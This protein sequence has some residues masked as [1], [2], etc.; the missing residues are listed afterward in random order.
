MC[1]EVQDDTFNEKLQV[2]LSQDGSMS[3]TFVELAIYLKPCNEQGQLPF[4]GSC[5][6]CLL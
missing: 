2:S 6:F 4:D 3:K 5:P 1:Y